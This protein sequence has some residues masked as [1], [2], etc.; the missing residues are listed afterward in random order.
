[1]QFTQSEYWFHRSLESARARLGTKHIYTLIIE[2]DLVETLRLLKQALEAEIRPQRMLIDQGQTFDEPL[3]IM[4]RR[5][6]GD[7]GDPPTESYILMLVLMST[8]GDMY[9]NLDAT[10]KRK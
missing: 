5:I 6:H 9:R 1:M 10:T 7:R 3:R 8:L 4:F 2:M